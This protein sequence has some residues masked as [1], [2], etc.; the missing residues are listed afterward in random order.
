[1]DQDVE[2]AEASHGLT[3]EPAGLPGVRQVG[4]ERDGSRAHSLELTDQPPGLARRAVV[5]DRDVQTG[6]RQRE[7][8]RPPHPTSTAG[9][10][11]ARTGWCYP[12][13]DHVVPR[14]ELVQGPLHH[15]LLLHGP[16]FLTA[17]LL[18]IFWSRID[19][20]FA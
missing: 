16:V 7:R 10:E 17:W 12:R 2:P 19:D 15:G 13:P 9:N 8:D 5:G 4:A 20:V 11:H 1:V 3:H 18:W 6:A 14:E